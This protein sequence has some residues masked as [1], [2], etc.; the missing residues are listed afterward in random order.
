MPGPAITKCPDWVTRYTLDT[1]LHD[2]STDFQLPA[3]SSYHPSPFLLLL[4]L[5]TTPAYTPPTHPGVYRVPPGTQA[6]AKFLAKADGVLS[7]LAVADQ[8]FH[9]VDPKLTVRWSKHGGL[10][11][12]DTGDGSASAWLC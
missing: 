12:G 1:L 7:G 10:T 8:V 6:V 11:G 9:I 4:P 3:V 2:C 5:L